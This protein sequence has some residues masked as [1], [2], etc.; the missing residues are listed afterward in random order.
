MENVDLLIS[1]E[2]QQ[3]M[4]LKSAFAPT[5]PRQPFFR[6]LLGDPKQSPGGVADGQRAH[7][8][9]LLKAP[10][11]LRAPTTWY[12][13]HE[14]PEV[15]HMLLRHGRGFSL[16][17]LEETATVLGHRP[18]GSSWFRSKPRLRSLV[19]YSPPTMTSPEWIWISRKVCWWV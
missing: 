12:M 4:D 3:D 14:I 18:L 8:T 2:A 19:S 5:V 10:I 11:G 15:F 17:D 13:P 1:E 6:L 16:S 9:L 7:R